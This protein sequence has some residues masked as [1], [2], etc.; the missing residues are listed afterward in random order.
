MGTR[1]AWTAERRARQREIIRGT[2]PWRFSTGPTSAEGKRRAS[3]NAVRSPRASDPRLSAEE[4]A[5][6]EAAVAEEI[7]WVFGDGPRFL[8]D[9]DDDPFDYEPVD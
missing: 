8:T 5:Q 7:A 2:R 4:L 6:I 9:P 1:I 3:R